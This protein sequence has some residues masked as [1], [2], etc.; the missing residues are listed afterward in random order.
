M[1][2]EWFREV[3]SSVWFGGGVLFVFYLELDLV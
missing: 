3:V 1:F 2:V